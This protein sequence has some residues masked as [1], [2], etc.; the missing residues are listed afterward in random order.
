MNVFSSRTVELNGKKIVEASAGTGKTYSIAVICLRLI[1][2]GVEIQKIL[3]VTF[4]QAATAELKGRMMKFVRL[5]L[6][7]L[8]GLGSDDKDFDEIRKIV[9]S[10]ENKAGLL[11]KV[12][13][14]Y[15]ALDELSVFTI[16]GFCRR[17][18]SENSFETGVLFNMELSTDNDSVLTDA[19]QSF[20]RKNVPDMPADVLGRISGEKW[21][22]VDELKRLV[23][24]RLVFK[25]V[26]YLPDIKKD[27]V[28]WKEQASLFEQ[29]ET[30][31]C[32]DLMT[33]LDELCDYCE[34]Y[35]DEERERTGVLSF[36]DLLIL[37]DQA[38]SDSSRKKLLVNTMKD[39]YSAVLI[40]EFQDTDPVQYK[41]FNTLF[42]NGD[43][44]LFFI[45]DPKQSIYSFR[46]ADIFAYLSAVSGMEKNA[47]AQK[48]T[49]NENYRSCSGLVRAV[50]AVFKREKPFEI[51]GIDFPSVSAVKSEKNRL[52]FKGEPCSGIDIRFMR[53]DSFEGYQ[54]AGRATYKNRKVK[55]EHARQKA[56]DDMVFTI[57]EMLR[58]NSD[59]LIEGKRVEASDIAVLVDTNSDADLV[60]R[61]LSLRGIPAVTASNVSV[62]LSSEAQDILVVSEAVNSPVPGR[63]KAALLTVFFAKD[64][65]Y[66][67]SLESDPAE[68]EK[69][70]FFFSELQEIWMDKGF[71]STMN[72]FLSSH[73]VFETVALGTDGERALTN[74]RQLIELIHTYEQENISPPQAT[75]DWFKEKISEAGPAEEEQLRLESDAQAVKIVTI[76]RSKGLDY[77]VVFC[78]A[79]WRKSEPF[80]SAYYLKYHENGRRILSFEQSNGRAKEQYRRENLSENLRLAYVAMT[81][82]KY[83]CII[84]WGNIYG[85]GSCALANLF[86][87]VVGYSDFNKCTDS[88]MLLDLINIEEKSEGSIKVAD[89]LKTPFRSLDLRSYERKLSSN[90]SF[91]GEIA[92]DWT[93]TSF[94]ALSSHAES[95]VE[96]AEL[97]EENQDVAVV[98][99]EVS[100]KRSILD[101]P[102]GA[103]AGTA[104][105][106]VFEE[107]DFSSEDNTQV[108]AQVLEKY[109]LKFS[110]SGEDM[111]PWVQECIN[112]V[113]DSPVFDGKT[114]RDAKPDEML[115]EM[116]FFFEIDNFKTAKI[117]E[118]FKG[119]ISVPEVSADGFIHGFI[120]LVFRLD[121]KYYI[122][123]WK[124]NKL[125]D[126]KEAYTAAAVLREMKKH[127]YIFQYMIYTAALDRY[128]SANSDNYKW[129]DF[130][131]ISYVFLRGPAFYNDLPD[132]N[133]F[134]SF[135]KILI[136]KEI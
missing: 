76:H 31:M 58:D 93:V 34:K 75:L 50:E 16:H 65:S 103:A 111:T 114:L 47:E 73:G 88:N 18:L 48:Y 61:N 30:D 123:D 119:K 105:H 97:Y 22:D 49:M 80:R 57:I 12:A 69:W 39:R 3:A 29:S 130:G 9:D 116:E 23:K 115:T 120:D 20:W 14:A 71:L 133:L 37:L 10:Y 125:G 113:L 62:Y 83:Q 13:K 38:L 128:L 25:D 56:V 26:L 36:D 134:E 110:E 52:T 41:I 17:I 8:K 112:D 127:N 135:K 95:S 46:N 91:N 84:Y 15:S 6:I 59:Y 129:S 74:I 7:Y 81:R 98:A 94:S 28:S 54:L 85:L 122:V 101:F 35:M 44:T 100:E 55:V 63:V 64:I 126:T 102:A 27:M 78:P 42:G 19:V 92:S 70:I 45:G 96:D 87:G 11:K 4:T 33:L 82:A 136:G 32:A 109:N 67:D 131:G 68:M 86:H 24:E 121:G 21:F 90:R 107:I 117:N 99:G 77:P 72:T 79:M 124:S 51:E 108:I 89:D 60:R 2:S 53:A 132:K 1:L 43:H 5:A 66:I 40:D 118:L 104:L 106:A